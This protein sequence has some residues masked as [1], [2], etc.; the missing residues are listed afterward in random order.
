MPPSSMPGGS[1]HGPLHTHAGAHHGL[2]S[3]TQEERFAAQLAL[4]RVSSTSNVLGPKLGGV[5]Q[6]ATL[7]GG[8]MR[9]AAMNS[10]SLLHGSGSDTFIGGAHSAA[11]ATIG[12]DT[13]IAGSAGAVTRGVFGTE[14]VIAHHAP[15]ITLGGDTINLAGTTAASVKA[16]QPD[17]AKA[18]AHTVSVG[19]KTTVTVSGLSPHDIAKLPH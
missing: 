3:L 15:S 12:N 16:T 6:S 14:P 2:A 11:A 5:T 19:D 4:S 18:K 1:Q 10:P 7:A 13:V 17:D 8:S 9:A